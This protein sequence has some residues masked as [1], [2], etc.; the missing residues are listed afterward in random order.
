MT[1]EN[2]IHRTEFIVTS[3]DTDMYSRLR[4]GSFINMLI[5]S[6]IQSADK[7]EFG[8]LKMIENKLFWVLSRMTVQ[9]SQPLKW[10]DKVDVITWPRD[11]NGLLYLRDFEIIKDSAV[12]GKATSGW[13]AVDIE[14]K[15]PKN[16]HF[17][18][19]TAFTTL[20]NRQALMEFPEKLSSVSNG[21]PFSINPSFF[22]LDMNR[23]VTSTRYIDWMMDTFS[24][25]FHKNHYPGSISI[26]YMKET[27]IDEELDLLCHK[28]NEHQ[29]SFEGKNRKSQ[30]PAF[31]AKLSF[32]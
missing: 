23:H 24:P 16:V 28:D 17:S 7:L 18:D 6:A 20:K 26:N 13:L 9:I 8:H 14:S 27:L 22:D 15:R 31:R 10:Y 19:P 11:I 1:E 30:S 32:K 12:I 5:Q 25:E 4:L 2:L 29:Y 21:D 3:A